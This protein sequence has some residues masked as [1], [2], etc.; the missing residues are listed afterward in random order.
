MLRLFT[1]RRKEYFQ[2]YFLP[3]HLFKSAHLKLVKSC[4]S[5]S[6]SASCSLC[7][8][9]GSVRHK[10]SKKK[11]ENKEASYAFSCPRRTHPMRRDGEIFSSVSRRVRLLFAGWR[12]ASAGI[13]C[14]AAK[15]EARS[16]AVRQNMAGPGREDRASLFYFSRR[17]WKELSVNKKKNFSAFFSL[18]MSFS[19]SQ[20][21]A[22]LHLDSPFTCEYD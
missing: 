10:S 21:Q 14:A 17:C 22:L 3:P 13:S 1:Q 20:Q 4:L 7:L 15:P 2:L 18:L 11:K 12:S 19:C 6:D 16:R 5:Q 8:F 9:R